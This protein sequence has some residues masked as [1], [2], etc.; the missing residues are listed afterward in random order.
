MGC[1]IQAILF[2]KLQ[3]DPSRSDFL[4]PIWSLKKLSKK[5]LRKAKKKINT[6]WLWFG[7]SWPHGIFS[8][9]VDAPLRWAAAS[10]VRGAAVALLR[11]DALRWW[12]SGRVGDWRGGEWLLWKQWMS[13]ILPGA[14]FTQNYAHMMLCKW[15]Q[16]TCKDSI[17]IFREILKLLL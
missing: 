6:I 12:G 10:R 16:S 3:K 4:L 11:F 2:L 5:A 1:T 7:I 15:Y 13:V 14:I 17:I 9:H 8:A